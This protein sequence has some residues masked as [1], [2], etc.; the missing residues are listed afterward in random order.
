ML[1]RL[2]PLFIILLIGIPVG[3]FLLVHKESVVSTYQSQAISVV[4]DDAV[5]IFESRSV[6]ELLKALIQSDPLFPSLQQIGEA[7]P[8]L[9]AFRKIDSLITRNARFNE[10][11]AHSPAVVSIH[12]TGKNQYQFLMILEIAGT[13]GTTEAG[14]LFAQLCGH[15]G[16]WSQR[17]YNGQQ[18]SR[19]TFGVDALLPG[20]SLAGNNKFLVLSPSP[21][22]LENA[23]RQM[24]QE[25]SLNN[26]KSFS[27]LSHTTGKNALASIYIN[28][29]VFPSM[30]QL[31]Q[32]KIISITVMY[33]RT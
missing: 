20:I 30:E 4:P 27:R 2:V 24:N 23:V 15:P 8:Y 11:Y 21:V 10:L 31:F 26:S 29:K 25:S 6:P 1:K 13:S 33:L 32:L 7:K 22:L 19:I 17:I 28:L 18:I 14:D 3:V 12:Q 16:Q 9:L 5:W